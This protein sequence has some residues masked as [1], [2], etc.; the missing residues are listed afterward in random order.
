MCEEKPQAGS[1]T[2]KMH[3]ITIVVVVATYIPHVE[4]ELQ[5]RP[6]RP[7]ARSHLL[8]KNYRGR[9]VARF[10]VTYPS[11]TCLAWGS[12]LL[13]S[14]WETLRPSEARRRENGR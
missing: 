14:P 10:P 13:P 8:K 6:A 7:H 1:A 3:I 4:L 9:R 11:P 5:L 12:N 2:G